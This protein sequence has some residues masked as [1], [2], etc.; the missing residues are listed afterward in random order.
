MDP[1]LEAHNLPRQNHEE[2]KTL[3]TPITS[4]DT[5]S[6]S[7][8]SQKRKAGPVD[9]TGEVYQI[10]QELTSILL[11]LF[12]KIEEKGIIPNIFHKASVFQIPK[13]DKDTTRKLNYRPIS[14]MNI[15]AKVLI[16]ISNQI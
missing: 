7:Q 5:E 16:K 1:F 2:T 10:F 14:Q 6:Y 4:K 3:I 15:D 11:K 9:F 12:Q 8:I 13:L